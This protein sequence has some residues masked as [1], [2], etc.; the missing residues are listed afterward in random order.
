MEETCI[1]ELQVWG[2]AP[3]AEAGAQTPTLRVAASDESGSDAPAN[4]EPVLAPTEPA[5]AAVADAAYFAVGGRGLVRLSAQ[6]VET[7]FEGPVVDF[8]VDG[9]GRVFVLGSGGGSPIDIG[10]RLFVVADGQRRELAVPDQET[11]HS[12]AVD[13]H[14]A[15][16]LAGAFGIW[17]RQGRGW[18]PGDV[19]D[20]AEDE[21]AAQQPQEAV[22]AADGVI[23][24]RGQH[25]IFQGRG[26]RY[27]EERIPL[28]GDTNAVDLAVAGGVVAVVSNLN[29]C[30]HRSYWRCTPPGW[31]RVTVGPDGT[32][33]AGGYDRAIVAP[34]TGDPV[35][36]ALADA[37]IVT[38]V[39][40]DTRGR[41]WITST[42]GL[43]VLG[44]DHAVARRWARGAVPGLG[45]H[46]DR[47]VVAGLGPELP[48]AP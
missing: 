31:R 19:M 27:R 33:A 48:P 21:F 24:A 42:G 17:R 45:G 22:V 47:I 14:G 11:F 28:F 39:A 3:G 34:P 38:D 29:L 6:G 12:I 37:G 7:L 1:S 15:P 4:D 43:S 8:A 41:T 5:P 30:V 2:E 32:V 23:W 35:S 46:A 36:V 44:P 26:G 16:V 25:T 40:R 13:A 18:S 9:E 20:D 10:R